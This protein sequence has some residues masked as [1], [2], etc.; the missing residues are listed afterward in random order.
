MDPA[1]KAMRES[2]RA[3][4]EQLGIGAG[5]LGVL[6]TGELLFPRTAG[7]QSCAPPGT[8]AKPVPWRRDCRPIRPRRPASTLSAGEVT[9]L[10]SAY[11]AMRDL[12]TSDPNDPRGFQHQANVHC[13]NCSATTQV[14]FKWTFF[15]WHRAELYFHERILGRLINDDDFRLPYWDWDVPSHRSLPGAYTNPNDATNPLFNG[16]RAPS[17]TDQMPA[18]WVDEDA[19]E[20]ILTLGNFFEFGGDAANNG[21]PE[22]SPHGPIHNWVDGDMS[23]FATAAQDPVFYAHHANVDKIWSDWNRLDSLHTN[24]TDPAF[25]DLTFTFFDEHKVWRSIK[26]SQVLDHE[27]RLRYTYGGSLFSEK[28]RCLILDWVVVRTTWLQRQ[29]LEWTP[30]VRDAIR[31]AVEAKARIRLHLEG[32]QLPTDRSE[33]YQ[34]YADAAEAQANKGPES[35]AFLGTASVV[36][37]D[38]KNEHPVRRQP[39]IILPVTSRVPDLLKR[40]TRIELYAVASLRKRDKPFPVRARNVYWSWGQETK[41]A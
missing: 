38:P 35:P 30:P 33:V 41:D 25:L 39:N 31:K 22:A 7:A 9:K 14:H 17:P 23:A 40:D 28:L 37:N 29:V 24:P 11:Q 8:T 34:I 26:A 4:L 16:T 32:L 13:F 19:M 10:K 3:F 20:S 15:A 27:N 6:G 12:Q 18:S 21:V 1:A 2:R 5:A 36:L